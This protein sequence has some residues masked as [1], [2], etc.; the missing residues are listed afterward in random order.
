ML[1]LLLKSVFCLPASNQL[2]EFT[3]N[4][5]EVS[6]LQVPNVAFANIIGRSMYLSTFDPKPLIGK[7]YEYVIRD[8]STLISSPRASSQINS[9]INLEKLAGQI[10][11]VY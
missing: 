2:S 9:K 8:A 1:F 6:R 5:H 4:I 10:V 11:W 3:S 7:D